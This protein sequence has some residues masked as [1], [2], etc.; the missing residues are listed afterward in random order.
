M[1]DDPPPLSVLLAAADQVALPATRIAVKALLV[2]CKR[3][4]RKAF[5]ECNGYGETATTPQKKEACDK[6][7]DELRRC[8]QT[9]VDFIKSLAPKDLV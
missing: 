5:H 6:A 2:G 9:R 1:G 4:G 3:K 7:A 8:L